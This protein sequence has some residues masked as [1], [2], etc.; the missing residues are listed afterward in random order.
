MLS[1]KRSIHWVASSP[2]S[3]EPDSAAIFSDDSLYFRRV[4]S[5]R[6]RI[7]WT[8]TGTTASTSARVR[9]I[10]FSVSSG[11]KRRR[12]TIVEVVGSAM[13]KWRKPQEWK[14]G[15]AITIVEPRR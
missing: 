8:I 12:S 5:G 4:S 14:S 1:P 15:A 9:S 11:S 3:A 2:G 10:A 6:P 13:T 7:R